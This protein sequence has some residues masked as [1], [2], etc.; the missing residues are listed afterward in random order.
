MTTKRIT[1]CQRD[2][3]KARILTKNFSMRSAAGYLRN[4][5]YSVDFTLFVL[6]GIGAR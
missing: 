4:R 3:R 6:L 1:N 5:G 2:I